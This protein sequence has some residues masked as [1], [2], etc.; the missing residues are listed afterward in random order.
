M[1]IIVV[2]SIYF[3]AQEAAGIPPS[4]DFRRHSNVLNR[5][6]ENLGHGS[7]YTNSLRLRGFEAHNYIANAPSLRVPEGEDLANT[8]QWKYWQQISRIKGVGDY[9]HFAGPISQALRKRV[10]DEKP[11]AILL[12]NPNLVTPRLANWIVKQDVKMYGQIASPLPPDP[13]F[14]NYKHIF[15]AIPDQVRHFSNLGVSSSFLP[16]GLDERLAI[17]KPKPLAEREHKVVFVGNVGRLHRGSLDL[18]RHV[19]DT[20]PGF[21]L[22]S[23]SKESTIRKAGLA[24][25]YK[26]AI[27]GKEMLELY[28]DSQVV[29]NRHIDMAGGRSGNYRMFEATGSG[30]ILLTETS[31]NMAEFFQPGKE[32]ICYGDPNDASEKILEILANP[33]D[34][35]DVALGGWKRLK[36]DHTI[37]SRVGEMLAKTGNFSK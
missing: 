30:S 13:Y 28:R 6:E 29:L 8:W 23:V 15:S 17:G 12:L 25:S 33:A 14:S 20:V 21:E 27:W 32:A 36:E 18:L 31:N 10:I 19:Q 22:Y 34:F 9:L 7:A 5:L 37:T 16:L 3:S 24:K 1:K 2:G 4:S 26:G 11:G 35:Q